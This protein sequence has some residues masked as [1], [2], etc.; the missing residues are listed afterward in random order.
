MGQKGFFP[1]C[2]YSRDPIQ[3]GYSGF[4]LPALAI[5]FDG[6]AVSFIPQTLQEL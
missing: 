3:T 4:F 6:E 1:L 2:S 5:I